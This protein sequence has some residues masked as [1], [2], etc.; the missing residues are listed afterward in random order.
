MPVIEERVDKLEEL[1]GKTQLMVQ[2]LSY[3]INRLSQEMREFKNEIRQE[4]KEFKAHTQATVDSM[5]EEIGN[6][7]QKMEQ[8]TKKMKEKIS[9]LT[10]KMEQDTKEM[11][12]ESNRQW[13][14]LSKKLGTMVEDIVAPNIEY[15]AEKYFNCKDCLRFMIRIKVNHAAIKG[16]NTEFDIIA[17]Y[18]DKVIVNECKSNVRTEDPEK[19]SEKLKEFFDYFPEYNGKELVPLF[20]SFYIPEH[21]LVDLSRRKIYGMAMKEDTMVILNPDL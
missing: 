4:T 14:K 17:V 21:V 19:F 11:K 7:T 10:Q 9:N 8:D 18:P 15:I 3:E 16:K 20:A 2:G 6:L 13:E 1:V 12:K 5:K